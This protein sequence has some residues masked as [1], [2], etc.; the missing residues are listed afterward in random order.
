MVHTAK[1]FIWLNEEDIIFL[2]DKY[3]TK[4]NIINLDSTGI[5]AHI[6]KR[7]VYTLGKNK[8][9]FNIREEQSTN[10]IMYINVD[11]ILLLGKEDIKEQDFKEINTI[12]NS[13]LFNI[14]EDNKKDLLLNRIDYRMDVKIP[15]ENEREVLMKL[16]KKTIEKYRFQRKYDQYNS[17]IYY[18]SK[19]TQATVY[20]K[21]KE[22]NFKN[23]KVEV[24]EENVLRFEVR[25]QNKHLNYRK[26]KYN[27]DKKLENYF[28][29]GLYKKYMNMYLEPILYRGNYYKI[30]QAKKIIYASKLKYKDK[31]FLQ[32]FL[33]DISKSGITGAKELK[34]NSRNNN[35]KSEKKVVYEK[36]KYSKYKFTKGIRLL[37]E[38]NIN[39]I[40][41]PKNW[42][43]NSFIN[44]PF[45]FEK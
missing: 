10:Y 25:L 36:Q 43:S 30:Y 3:K 18:N 11:F 13:Y 34:I 35:D 44:N 14:F 23:K 40:L 17:T 8:L 37:E 32:E 5:T 4:P 33:T 45:K 39:P 12:L 38:L 26:N 29:E 20:D 7:R 9:T 21:T 19:S 27:I 22:R 41:I 15:N 16:Y 1:F 6:I 2:E 24:F 28:E 42:K 31:E